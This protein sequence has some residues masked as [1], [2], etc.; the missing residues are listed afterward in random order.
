MQDGGTQLLGPGDV[1]CTVRCKSLLDMEYHIERNHTTEGIGQKR[2]SERKLAE[3]FISK[4][5][6]FDQDWTNLIEFKSC[7][8][9]EGA[10]SSARPDFF[11]P[12]ESARL[13]A[14][15]L[16]GN[17]ECAHRQYACDFRRTFNITQALEQNPDFQGLPLLYIRFNPHHY[18]RD[19]VC[20]SQSLQA[21]HELLWDTIQS[22]TT[23]NHGVNM[24][25]VNYDRT[26]GVL[27]I[28]RPEEK[29]DYVAIYEGCVLKD[30]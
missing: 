23:V 16:V 29:N 8:N 4:C 18:V 5:I 27:D 20:F 13:G 26:D 10:S 1:L 14:A 25:F 30:V 22:I 2:H 17:D 11:L 28:F 3:F 24:V 12:V 21:G 7:K 15:V 9:I 6:T 19:G